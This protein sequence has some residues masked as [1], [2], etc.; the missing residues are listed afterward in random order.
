MTLRPASSAL[1]VRARAPSL[2]CVLE[3]YVGI[4]NGLGDGQKASLLEHP[5]FKPCGLVVVF[6]FFGAVVADWAK[7]LVE[8]S[9]LKARERRA[10]PRRGG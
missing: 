5:N 6:H 3:A 1:S 8:P 10:T 2:R 7:G 9:V 4:V